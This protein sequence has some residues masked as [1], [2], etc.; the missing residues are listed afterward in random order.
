MFD[1]LAQQCHQVIR[2]KLELVVNI[3]VE[4]QR[5]GAITLSDDCRVLGLSGEPQLRVK[6]ELRLEYIHYHREHFGVVAGGV[7]GTPDRV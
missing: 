7:N 2:R 1:V 4:S 5:P 3:K 6:H